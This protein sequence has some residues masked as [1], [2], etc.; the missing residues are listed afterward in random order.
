MPTI[1]ATAT[2]EVSNPVTEIALHV[3]GLA[4]NNM[5][6]TFDSEP[7]GYSQQQLLAMLSG[8]NNLNGTGGG[9]QG[10]NAGSEISNLAMGE[11]NTYFTQSLLEPLSASLGNA[12]GLQNLQLT[13][14]FTSG[15]GFNAVKAFGKH[16]TAVF[17]ENLGTPSTRSLSIEAH[18]GQSTAFALTMHTPIRRRWSA[19]G[20]RPTCSATITA[21]MPCSRCW[22]RAAL[23]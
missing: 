15:F 8:L 17:S 9:I 14:D 11:V 13:D 22:A 2:T 18:H 1:D 19:T 16:V 12:L 20:L 21:R 7:G 4:P 6:L 5:Q 10:V 3:T 23:R